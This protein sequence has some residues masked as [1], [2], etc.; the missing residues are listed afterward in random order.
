[1]LVEREMYMS[2]IRPFIG[3]DIVKVLTGIRRSGK[4]VMLE[5]IKKEL[6]EQGAR[7]SNFFSYNF[8][9]F[10]LYSLCTA[11]ALNNEIL[12]RREGTEGKV[13]LFFDEIQ[14]VK[15]WEKTV[16][17]LRVTIDCDIYITGSNAKLLS[18]ELSTYLAGRY[19]EFVIYPF[20]FREFLTLYRLSFPDEGI[21]ECFRKYMT[22]G[23]MPYLSVLNY[24]AEAAKIY[25]ED[26]YTSIA[27]K[28]IAKR[29]NIRDIDLLERVMAYLSGNIGRTFSA[30]SIS[31]YFKSEFRKVSVDTLLNYIRFSME[32][33]LLYQVKREDVAGKEIL[34]TNEKYYIADQGLR[35]AKYGNNEKDVELVLEN[36]VFME[37]LRRGYTV[38]TGRV[39]DKE[40]DFIAT[41]QSEKIYVQ[42]TYLLA[43]ESTIEREFGVYSL[44]SDNWPK[45]V[46]SMDEFNMSRDGIKHMNVR[47]FLLADKWN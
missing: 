23:G 26:T 10:A 39:G 13:Y 3:K 21:P 19:V 9:D 30:L 27:L 5:L 36:I 31:R 16:N 22:L 2:R 32:A 12:R 35:E 20:S 15:E 11:E 24:N 37:L 4:S 34:S 45:Y 6:R 43:G 44:V 8:E 38:H 33:F 17:S 42:V 14:E 25:L 47:D 46:V 1:M 41:R 7:D 40:I 29:N 18:S 28:D